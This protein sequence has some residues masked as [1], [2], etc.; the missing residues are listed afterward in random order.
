VAA[1]GKNIPRRSGSY[2][3]DEFLVEPSESRLGYSLIT[4]RHGITSKK[5][6]HVNV[7]LVLTVIGPD[8]P[9]LVESLSQAVAQQE[10]NWLE[11]RM[12]RMAGQFAGILRVNI[13]EERAEALRNDLMALETKGILI[14][15]ETSTAE[16]YESELRPLT[17]T[18]VG[19]DRPGIIHEISQ[20][21]AQRG[22]NVDE[23]TTEQS[24]APMSGESLFRA[25]AELRAPLD[26]NVEDL[27]EQLEEIAQ[28]LM[29]DIRLDLGT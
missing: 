19:N 20:I 28:D 14:N 1:P 27:R 16:G 5:E 22:V 12:A 25:N 3:R 23:L 9:G 10:G 17:L 6:S 26:L 21:L 11:S 29:V 13:E 7:S 2:F 8:R 24:V 18:L 15:V 4:T